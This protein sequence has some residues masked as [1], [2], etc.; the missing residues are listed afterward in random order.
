MAEGSARHPGERVVLVRHRL[1]DGPRHRV[2]LR[3]GTHVLERVGWDVERDGLAGSPPITRGRGRKTPRHASTARCG[4]SGIGS[5]G[6]ARVD[7][8][9]QGRMRAAALEEALRD[10][11]GPTIVC[12]QAGEVNTGAFDPLRRDR[13][14]CRARPA[15]GCTSTAR[16]ACGRPPLRRYAT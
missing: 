15:P 11:S 8:D 2:S 4:F 7:V 10:V 9:D 1:P 14:V 12:A 3:L 13:G 6:T 16:S 5:G